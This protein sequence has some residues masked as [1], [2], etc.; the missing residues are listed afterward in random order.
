MPRSGPIY[1]EMSFA[2]CR[3][4][5]LTISSTKLADSMDNNDVDSFW[6]HIRKCNKSKS[7]MSNCIESITGEADI[8]KFWRD[9]HGRL[10]NSSMNTTSKESV[11]DSFKKYIV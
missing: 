2:Q 6:K 10:L 4:D 1:R 9:H 7:T 11:C 5:E 3:L 8:A